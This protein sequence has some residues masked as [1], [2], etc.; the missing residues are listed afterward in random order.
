M[1]ENEN[2][3]A[4]LVRLIALATCIFFAAHGII[5]QSV[6]RPEFEVSAIK[7]NN[8]CGAPGR[9]SGGLTSPG[10][11][12]LECAQLRDLIL[13]AYGIYANGSSPDPRGFRIQVLGGPGWI[14]SDRYDVVAKA[15]GDPPPTQMYGT[16]LQALL[17]DRF[18]LNSIVKQG[19]FPYTS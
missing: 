12:T 10:R 2:G 18:K 19:K 4:G 15:E 13:T 3:M 14:D 6:S 5:A 16:M 8:G 7:P 17:E 1:E 11:M 9:G